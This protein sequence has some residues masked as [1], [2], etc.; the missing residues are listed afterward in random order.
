MEDKYYKLSFFAYPNPG[1]Y[2]Q[3]DLQAFICPQDYDTIDGARLA[4]E[5]WMGRYGLTKSG[6]F[7]GQRVGNKVLW[8]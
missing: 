8:K 4:A 7:I 3:E 2:P 5:Y 1:E 6:V